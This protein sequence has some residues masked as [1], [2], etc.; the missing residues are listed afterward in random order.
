MKIQQIDIGDID[1]SK[2]LR[3]VDSAW[4][5]VLAESI[6]REGLQ[7][8]IQV[9]LDD[10]GRYIL[11]AGGHRL[12]A[13]RMLKLK[14]IP[15]FILDVD[16]S[17]AR[18]LE[19]IENLYRRELNPFDQAASLSELKAI[20]EVEHPETIV[21]GDRKSVDFIERNQN[22]NLSLCFSFTDET[23]EKTGYDKR[24]IER[25]IKRYNGLTQYS[26]D[27]IKGSWLA[28]NGAVLDK[29]AKLSPDLQKTAVDEMVNDPRIK[30]P[31]MAF[32]IADGSN[33]ESLANAKADP[34]SK[35]LQHYYSLKPSTQTQFLEYLANDGLVILEKDQIDL[36]IGE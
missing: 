35:M 7:S 16:W 25:F 19:I 34:L 24:S 28:E 18:A 5:E 4:A 26:R 10:D 31:E 20:Y 32:K 29:I 1:D 2:R 17:K 15:A 22:D 6:A 14:T 9:R 33:I 13:C 30:T 11:V 27:M 3:D 23:A 8:P 21:G 12:A 36:A